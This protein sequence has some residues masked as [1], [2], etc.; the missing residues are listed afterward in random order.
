[1]F[2]VNMSQTNNIVRQNC[3]KSHTYV[4][5]NLLCPQTLLLPVFFGV[6]FSSITTV[7]MVPGKLFAVVAFRLQACGQWSFS[8]LIW[9]MMYL[10]FDF[11][12]TPNLVVFRVG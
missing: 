4:C 10:K 5:T 7:N 11:L 8:K 3:F 1:M 2:M 12:G 6:F 9:M